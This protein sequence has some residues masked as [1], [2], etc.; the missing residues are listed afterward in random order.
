MG[1]TFWGDS[2]SRVDSTITIMLSVS[3]LYIVIF[4]SIPMLG[5]LTKFDRYIIVVRDV[6][7]SSSS[8]ACDSSA[9]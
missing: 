8:L 3:A 6:P 1:L 9:S 2:S 4:S 5:Y 7:S